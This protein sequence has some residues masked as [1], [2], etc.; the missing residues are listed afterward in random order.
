MI[1]YKI[2]F[3]GV[4][5]S[6][7]EEA[8]LNYFG[9][10]TDTVSFN[11][12][13]DVFKA[14]GKGYIKYGILPVENSS[15]GSVNEVYDLLRKYR[16]Y[17]NGEIIIKVKQN[18]IGIKGANLSDIREVYSHHQGYQQSLQF[19]RKN[20]QLKFVPYYNT[21][22]SAKFV[23]ESMD[24]TKA[25]VASERAAKIY[26]LAVLESDLNFN[27]NNYTRFIIVGKNLEIDRSADKISLVLTIRHKAGS[28]CEVLNLF[29]EKELNLLK[30]ES[31][32]MVDKS[33]EYFFHLDFEGNLQNPNVYS[34]LE[35]L[36]SK[37]NYLKILGN[38]KKH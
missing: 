14:I 15:T 5:G 32:P 8:L 7:S 13:E 36:K 24:K 12:F 2:G 38:Y 10:D 1:K 33:W 20:P 31:R 16:C 3:Q 6:F 35:K 30:I 17:I 37:V 34:I 26:N 23:S 22:I 9:E 25:A 28:L 21:A 19:F 27:T 29:A 4:E 11:L 18:L